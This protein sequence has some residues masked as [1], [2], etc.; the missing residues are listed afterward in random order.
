MCGINGIMTVS[1]ALPDRDTIT[2]MQNAL[3]HRGPDGEGLHFEGSVGMAHRR[4]AIIDLE[5][6]AQPLSLENGITLNANAEIYNYLELKDEL[7][8]TR[9]S[10]ASDCEVPLH[11]YAKYGESYA[12]YLR[13]MYAI[14][15]HDPARRRLV[16]SRDPFGIKQLYYTEGPFGFAFASEPQAL[17]ASGLVSADIRRNAAEEL[18]QLQ[19]ST[20]RETVLS[21]IFRVLPGET[22]IVEA[23]RIVQRFR[24]SALPDGPPE[25]IDETEALRRVEEALL[26]SVDVHQRSDVPYGMFLSGGIDSSAVLAMMARLNDQP[27]KAFTVGFSDTAAADERSDAAAIAQALGAEHIEVDFTEQDFWS[28]VPLVT[29]AMDDPVADYAELPTYKLAATAG[30][31]LKVILC[32]EGGDELFG[33]Y[34]RYRSA[35]RPWWSH[36][37]AMRS[38]GALDGMHILREDSRDWRS[39]VAASETVAASSGRSRLQTAQATDCADWLPHDLLIKL[40]R[41]LMAH[42]VEG[43]TPMLDSAIAEAVFRLPDSLKIRGRTGKWILRKWLADVVP[44]AKPFSRKRGFTVPVGEWIIR[45]GDILGPLV[46]RQA[47]ITDLCHP[48]RVE[49]IF[50]STRR[51]AGFAAWVL[52]FYAIWHRQHVEGFTGEGD[53]F[54]VLGNG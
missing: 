51:R 33:G 19:F 9:F 23:G 8:E 31:D 49:A 41:C 29:R 10:T 27:V 32:G 43:R 26:N 53:V 48:D 13:G 47:G 20:G 28:T 2:A 18:L 34:G 6:G 14:A 15:I 12:E 46:A 54:A 4:L 24:R 35:I 36:R 5:T 21:N 42:G 22:I 3:T 25:D 40:D 39:G 37:R 30:Q 52:L 11:L 17:L 16:L 50:K 7:K 45:K 38:R 1:G 44:E